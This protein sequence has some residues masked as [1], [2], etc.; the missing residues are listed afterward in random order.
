MKLKNK[1]ILMITVTII[2]FSIVVSN[3]N[4]ILLVKNSTDNYKD[5]ETTSFEMKCQGSENPPEI[6]ALLKYSTTDYYYFRIQTDNERKL[7]FIAASSDGFLIMNITNEESPNLILQ[8]DDDGNITTGMDIGMVMD[9][10]VEDNYAYLQVG[11]YGL[12]ILDISDLGNPEVV[13]R[14]NPGDNQDYG[15]RSLHLV[16][17][18]LFF[19]LSN[20]F[21]VLNV[22]NPAQPI[23]IETGYSGG[24]NFAQ[25]NNYL[26]T[27]GYKPIIYQILED[28]TL[29]H[30]STIDE[31]FPN[32][33]DFHVAGDWL[34]I[35][36]GSIGVRVYDIFDP[37]N[38]LFL[39]DFHTDCDFVE[40]VFVDHTLQGDVIY[41]ADR[42][43]SSIYYYHRVN[44]P[45]L[46]FNNTLF[47]NTINA[48]GNLVLLGAYDLNIY[49]LEIFKDTD[50]DGMFDLWEY[51]HGLNFTNSL[52]A[53]A[54]PDNDNLT[55]IEEFNFGTFPESA[56]IDEDSMP[57][58]WEVLYDACDPNRYDA[59]ADPDNDNLTNIEEYNYG[60]SPDL[61]DTD[62]DGYTDSEEIEANTDP[63]DPEDFPKKTIP[64]FPIVIFIQ[65]SFIG[66]LLASKFCGKFRKQ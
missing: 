1:Q 19:S 25:Y 43:G 8:F 4:E 53:D 52:D 31:Y 51:S 58:N 62:S 41:V 54:D 28:K 66:I 11:I 34:Y 38:P 48:M 20:S 10:I 23:I 56:D 44:N 14:Y 9:V 22:T 36:A 7:A 46:I 42:Q 35:S 29:N 37:E 45:I 26:I 21:D 59:D 3:N 16:E 12:M 63:N 60:T 47:S 32:Y 40:E 5:T 33:L 17:N 39:F 2:F 6:P 64:G 61:A 18:I 55:N 13:C 65:M 15:G 57:D 24:F 30:V 49:E 50:E 27:S